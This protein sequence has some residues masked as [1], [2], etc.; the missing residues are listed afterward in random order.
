MSSPIRAARFHGRHDLRVEEIDPLGTPEP[1]W[2]RIAVEACGICA[3]DTHEYRA[4]PVIIPPTPHPVSGRSMPLTMG[5]EPAG[6]VIEVGDGVAVSVGTRVAVETNVVCHSCFWC[7]MGDF[8]LCSKLVGLGLMADGGLAEEMLAPAYMC[9]PCDDVA[10]T[11]AALAEP[12][13]VA[14]RAVRRGGVTSGSTIGIVG[15]GTIGLLLLQVARH[16]G[17]ETIVVIEPVQ[18]RRACA[19]RLGA[20]L[21]IEPPEA[22]SAV[23]ELTGTIGLDVTFESAGHAD[24]A[25]LAVE[26][27]RRGGRTV[28]M[29]VSTQELR[30]SLMDMLLDEKEVTTSLSHAYA[31]DFASAV[32][33]LRRGRIDTASIVTDE[34]P[35][36]DVVDAF[37]MVLEEPDR[38]LKV[39]VLPR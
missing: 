13:S 30:L 14:V 3:T 25:A 23:A 36:A 26:L 7:A 34:V 2:V 28:L 4:G 31:T 15:A 37:R 11:A 21:A 8:Q 32:D 35:L 19:L 39:M 12:L 9:F 24:A 16:A 6:R 29:G 20:D 10:P 1:G 33:L 27:A 22:R 38:H 18:E 17:A 5:H